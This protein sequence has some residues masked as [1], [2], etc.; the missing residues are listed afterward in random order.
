M[1]EIHY[2]G[3]KPWNFVPRRFQ[4]QDITD[5]KYRLDCTIP[6]SVAVSP[7]CTRFCPL[8]EFTGMIVEMEKFTGEEMTLIDSGRGRE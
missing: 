3:R 7:P 8:L 6:R 4:F 5:P 1:F 2:S